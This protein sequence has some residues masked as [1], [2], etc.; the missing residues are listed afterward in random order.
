MKRIVQFIKDWTLPISITM[1]IVLYF[2]YVNIHA[3]D[4][5]HHFVSDIVSVVQPSLIFTMLFLSFCKVKAKELQPHRWQLQLLALQ[6][7]PFIGLALPIIL[8]H[9]IPCR[10]IIE[11]AMLCIICPTATAASVVAGK[12]KGDANAVISYTCLSNLLAAILIPAVVSLI[13]SET[14]NMGIID[15]FMI[16]MGRVFPLLILPLLLAFTIKYMSPKLHDYL[17]RISYISFYLWAV[18]LTLSIG[19]TTKAMVHSHETIGT[20][21]GIALV[22]ALCC[23]AQFAFGRIIGIRHNSPIAGAQSLGQKNT[24]FGIWVAYTFMSPVTALAG[25]FYSVWH[26]VVNSYQLYKASKT[27]ATNSLIPNVQD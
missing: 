27:S 14:N 2:V 23:A 13:H 12:L 1:G 21:I 7:L 24:A 25:G 10:V 4:N 3:L 26:N 6:A 19:I 11:S 17:A 15:S 8:W 22:S 20:Y 18:T 16:I 5:T 9:D